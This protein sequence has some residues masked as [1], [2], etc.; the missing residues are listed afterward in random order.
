M[1]KGPPN[2]CCPTKN[3]LA[4]QRKKSGCGTDSCWHRPEEDSAERMSVHFS[5]SFPICAGQPA[6][7]P[8]QGRGREHLPST[9]ALEG[10]TVCPCHQDLPSP[11]HDATQVQLPHCGSAFYDET[12]KETHQPCLR[13]LSAS[14]PLPRLFPLPGTLFLPPLSVPVWL[15][16]WLLPHWTVSPM[17]V[18][19]AGLCPVP[20]PHVVSAQPFTKVLPDTQLHLPNSLPHLA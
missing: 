3:L 12:G 8:R 17:K 11:V 18:G 5:L 14:G 16:H 13:L 1:L 2:W 20:R 7:A 15:F 4:T 6:W 10:L 9:L 19:H